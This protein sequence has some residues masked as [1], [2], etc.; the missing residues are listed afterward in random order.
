MF[1]NRCTKRMY[2]IFFLNTKYIHYIH[3]Y[4]RYA[5]KDL[6]LFSKLHQK[7]S[8]TKG[9]I[10][11]NFYGCA[12][13]TTTHCRLNCMRL[14]FVSA[15]AIAEY[16]WRANFKLRGNELF[17]FMWNNFVKPHFRTITGGDANWLGWSA[18]LYGIDFKNHILRYF[19]C[20]N[21]NL[22]FFIRSFGR[23]FDHKF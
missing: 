6:P 7:I 20:E 9:R 19:K 15:S 10:K 16:A 12:S 2:N 1:Y 3:L 22:N 18:V 14:Y 11:S 23:E 8:F 5:P 13:F 17:A 4:I 21:L